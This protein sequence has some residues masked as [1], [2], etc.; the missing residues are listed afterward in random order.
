[1]D[2]GWGANGGTYKQRQGDLEE[3]KHSLGCFTWSLEK[4]KGMVVK[5][6][7]NGESRKRTGWKMK[8]DFPGSSSLKVYWGFFLVT[9]V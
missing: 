7:P 8:A 9:S 5:E 6:S 1:M 4:K 3:D 2:E